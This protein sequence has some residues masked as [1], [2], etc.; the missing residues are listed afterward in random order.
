MIENKNLGENWWQSK[1]SFYLRNIWNYH[2][3]LQK[4]TTIWICIFNYLCAAYIYNLKYGN[5][6]NRLYI[7]NSSYKLY[8]ELLL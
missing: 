7:A 3:N 1:T 5:V 4:E 6:I 8:T 2:N